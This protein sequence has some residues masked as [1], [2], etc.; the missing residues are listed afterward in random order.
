MSEQW[1]DEEIAPVLLE[2]SKKCEARNVSFM[3]V[4]E[5][6]H[7]ERGRTATIAEDAGLE[8]RML[9][10]C[11]RSAPNVDQYVINLIRYCREHGIATDTSIVMNRLNA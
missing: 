2:L 10:L 6:E 3:A 4:V 11:A 1:Y 9:D 5:Y 8:M 7:G